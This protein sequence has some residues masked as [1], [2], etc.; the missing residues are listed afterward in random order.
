[1][2][3]IIL[4]HDAGTNPDD[5][6]GLLLLL[7]HPVVDLRLVISGNNFP[8]ERARFAHKI[9]S[10]YGAKDIIVCAG[11]ETGHIEFHAHQYIEDYEPNISTDYQAAIKEVVDT[12]N[13]VVYVC[14]QGCAN[15]ATFLQTYPAYRDTFSIFHMGAKLDPATDFIGGGTNM[16]AD[17]LAAKYLYELGLE[18][19]WVVGSHTT[20]NDA[21][22][23]T[24]ESALYKRLASSSVPN[25]TLLLKHLH[26]YFDRR[27]VWPALHD[28]LTTAVALGYKYVTFVSQT[29]EFNDRGEY[30]VSDHGVEVMISEPA[31]QQPDDFMRLMTEM[32]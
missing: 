9:I 30:R 19:F 3:T 22:R 29:I 25:H 15:I 14:I 27:D 2:K 23:V 32:V 5:F 7:H 20:I 6:F 11:E 26:D 4:D 10:Q 21:I 18:K 1:M 28:P 24:P 12:Y 31:I 16:E 8:R 17:P 13:D